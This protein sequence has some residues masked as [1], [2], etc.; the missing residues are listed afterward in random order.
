[1]SNS[2]LSLYQDELLEILAEECCEIGVE[3]S[4]I[5]RFG[6]DEESWH[7]RGKTHREC[8]AQELGDISCM[9]ELLIESDIGITYNDIHEAKERKLKKIGKWMKHTKPEPT[10]PGST[11]DV[12]SKALDLVRSQLQN[13]KEL[14]K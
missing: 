3:K 5:F 12:M 4:K 13:Y 2:K 6:I 14:K 9:I 7:V 11:A 10:V 8:L 1:M